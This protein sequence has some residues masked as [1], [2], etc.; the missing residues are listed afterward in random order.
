MSAP[1]VSVICPTY[2]RGRAIV[3][4]LDSVRAQSVRDWE[5]LVVSD[6]SDDDTDEVVAGVVARDPRVRLIRTRR[7]GH[8]SGPRNVA[9]DQARG[10]TIAYIDHDD[11]WTPNH[12]SRVTAAIDSGARFVATAATRVRP[13]GAAVHTPPDILLCWHPELQ[14]MAPLFEPSRVAHEAG[15]AEAVGG[16]RESP[17]GLEDWD[18]WLRFADAGV[19]CTTLMESTVRL[20]D[21]PA[22]RLHHMP[23]GFQLEIARFPD[24]RTARAAYR[25]LKDP[26]RSRALLEACRQDLLEWYGALADDGGLVRPLGWRPE[27]HELLAAVV[28]LVDDAADPWPDLTLVRRDGHVSL[29]R[30]LRCMT[31]RHA[32]RVE[33]LTR[34]TQPR[35]RALIDQVLAP[36][37]GAG[38]DTSPPT[39]P[40]RERRPA[41]TPAWRVEE[42]PA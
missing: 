34:R 12:L 26:R 30:V 39:V 13:S 35:Q 8:P 15:L 40:G 6:A 5:L 14:L 11:H 23:C 36:F 41:Q 16:W 38:T 22:T 25:A 42:I 19:W 20:L 3:S 4:T 33:E 18:L 24:A 2:N 7:F 21:D 29:V 1:R 17:V 10:G 27:R 32:A 9:L 31:A 37:V 28:E